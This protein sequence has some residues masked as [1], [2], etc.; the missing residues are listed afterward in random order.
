MIY[1][2]VLGTLLTVFHLTNAQGGFLGTATLVFSALGGMTAGTVSDRIGRVRTLALAVVIYSVF[3]FLSGLSTSFSMLI[4]LRALEG[5][6]FG[7]EWAVGSVLIAETVAARYRGRVF[8]L[9]QAAW[10]LGWGAAVLAAVLILPN[11][12]AL[13]WRLM[14]WVG[15]LPAL[16]VFYIVRHVEEP[17]IWRDRQK[18][19]SSRMSFLRLFSGPIL[20]TTIFTSLLAL[21]AMSGYYAIFTWLPTYLNL[22]RH[23]TVIGSGGYLLVV[24]AGSF[25]GYILSGYLTDWLG[26]KMNFA[27]FS[28]CSGAIILLYTNFNISDTAMLALSFPLGFFASGIFSG[29]GPFLSELF[30]TEMRGA[31]QGFSYSF[32][33]GCAAFAPL[34]VGAL[35]GVYGLAGAISIFGP[36]T[37]TLC[38]IALLF[39]P[40]TKGSDLHSLSTLGATDTD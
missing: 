8:G 20:R 9:V 25:F 30:P 4:V 32:G 16:L 33:R 1:T 7:G 26:R 5:L 29:F 35:A 12:G 27:I 23:L 40:E 28:V 39:L 24:I 14:F 38:L 19:T 36:L 34:I 17:P 31:G 22:D 21:G 37:Y 2:L 6:G 11:A 13:G 15:I 18:D 3:T 10:A